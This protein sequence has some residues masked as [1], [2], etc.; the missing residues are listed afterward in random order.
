[1]CL[2]V[3]L[4]GLAHAG[5]AGAQA[6]ADCVPGGTV[7]QVNACALRDFQAA[8]T[9]IGVLYADVMRALAAHERP[10]LRREHTAWMQQRNA[11]C[12]QATRAVEQQA[13]GPRHYHECLREKTRER[14]AG[15][16]KWLSADTPAKDD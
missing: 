14:R 6:G 5:L 10:Q 11:G 12:K 8:D 1:M 15:L 13:D 2:A 7:E 4:A 3:L 16:M 9:E